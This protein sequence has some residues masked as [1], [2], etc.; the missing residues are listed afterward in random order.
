MRFR[1]ID[2]SPR[3]TLL[4]AKTIS[5]RILVPGISLEM[6]KESVWCTLISSGR[7]VPML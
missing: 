4:R 1:S 3:P 2:G 5:S 6:V 7:P